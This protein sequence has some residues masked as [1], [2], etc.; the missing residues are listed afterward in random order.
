VL[1]PKEI[2]EYAVAIGNEGGGWLIMGV[3]DRKPRTISNSPEKPREELLRIQSAVLDSAAI[4]VILHSVNTSEG[5]VLAIEIPSRLPGKV[6]YTKT[7]KY[8]M[9]AGES[10]RAMTN[11]EIASIFAEASPQ[12][13]RVPPQVSIL[14]DLRRLAADRKVVRVQP[15]I[16]RSREMDEF[17]VEG[18]SDKTV[19]LHKLSSGHY[20]ELPMRRVQEVLFTSDTESPTIVLNGRLQWI[21]V[22]PGWRFL[23]ESPTTEREK[24]LGFE[25]LSSLNDA[26][27]LALKQQLEPRGVRFYFSHEANVSASESKGWE[28]VYDTDGRLFRIVNG[29]ESLILMALRS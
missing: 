2:T 3:T 20:I 14:N 9:R 18:A 16:P 25:K 15:I 13:T 26:R 19:S 7:G 27:V 10:L 12:L 21:S 5:C 24:S 17:Q 1:S 23:A 6:F 29:N 22:S 4:K 11:E 8:L 28:I